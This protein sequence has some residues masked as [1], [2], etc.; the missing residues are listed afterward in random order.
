MDVFNTNGVPQHI[1]MIMKESRIPW[2]NALLL[3][4]KPLSP[5]LNFTKMFEGVLQATF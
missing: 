4:W 2:V 1:V 3:S 5:V